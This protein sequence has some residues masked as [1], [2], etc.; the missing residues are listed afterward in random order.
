[1]LFVRL[2]QRARNRIVMPDVGRERDR[3]SI[4]RDLLDRRIEFLLLPAQDSHTRT[5]AGEAL[6]DGQVDAAPSSGDEGGLAVE[7]SFPE[8]I[9]H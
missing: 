3:T 7:D 1:M 2:P 6:R 9:R 4:G 5:L 8:D